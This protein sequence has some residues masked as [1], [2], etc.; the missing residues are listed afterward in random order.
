MGMLCENEVIFYMKEYL[1]NK[2]D[3]VT[4]LQNNNK[5]VDII[6]TNSDDILYIEAKGDISNRNR[7]LNIEKPFSNLQKKHY[8]D[9]AYAQLPQLEVK[10]NTRPTM[11]GM[12]VSDN[13]VYREMY[14]RCSRRMQ[15][16][17]DGLWFVASDGKVEVA[18][19]PKKITYK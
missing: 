11:V 13:D 15:L 18:L 16:M 1:S 12:V 14:R 6:A 7:K 9:A 19:E 10:Y 8:W 17:G 5:G 2:W 3:S 4:F